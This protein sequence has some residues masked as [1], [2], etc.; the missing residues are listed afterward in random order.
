MKRKASSDSALE[1]RLAAEA[2]L[3]QSKP[4]IVAF[5]LDF[6]LWPNNCFEKTL[7]PYILANDSSRDIDTV[8]CRE[9][10]TSETI[11]FSLF[12]ESRAVLDFCHQSGLVL[13]IASCSPVP[14][15]A[16]GILEAIGIWH[17]FKFPQIYRGQKNKHFNK[18][19][20]S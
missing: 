6:T 7:P 13:T 18:L 15:S 11:S 10:G 8:I 14:S 16:K 19:R 12:K 5:D 3:L 20:V 17:Y 4:S 9:R 1:N 2:I